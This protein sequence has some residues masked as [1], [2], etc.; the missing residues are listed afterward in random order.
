MALVANIAHMIVG[1]L[2]P[3]RPDAAWSLILR[4][5]LALGC[6]S[7]FSGSCPHSVVPWDWML[8]SC[9]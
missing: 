2:R 8:S 5:T 7:S 1:K 9:I 6:L 3:A 4:C